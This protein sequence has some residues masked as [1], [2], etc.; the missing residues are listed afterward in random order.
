[1][2]DVI[3]DRTDRDT[4]IARARRRAA[5]NL[6]VE[7]IWPALLPSMA[8]VAA[9]TVLALLDLPQRLPLW[10]QVPLLVVVLVAAVQLAWVRLRHLPAPRS[11]LI[12]RRI[13]QA[14]GLRHRPMQALLDRPAGGGEAG[15]VWTAHLGRV[16][17]G[18]GRLDAGWPRLGLLRHDPYRLSLAL[19]P[20]LLVT[21]LV[22]GAD[23]PGRL[24]TGFLP[25]LVVPP[26]PMP[27]LQAWITPPDYAHAA[28]VFL[29]GGHDVVSVPAGSV[30][31]LSLTGVVGRPHLALHMLDASADPAGKVR[32]ER[33]AAGS[34]SLQRSL[35]AGTS[36]TL[37]ANGRALA[38]WTLQVTPAPQV[39]VAWNGT[40][41]PATQPWLTRLPW[42][43]SHPYGVSALAAEI[44]LADPVGS[45]GGRVS[46]GGAIAP[47]QVPVA[48]PPDARDAR[49]V[50]LPDL[51][52]DP[53]AGEAVIG[54]LLA[55][56]A[57]GHTAASTEARF[58]LPE[59]P[60]HNPLAR[61]VLEARKR[62][63]L[64]RETRAATAADLQA[65]G[66]APGAFATDP[67]LFLNLSSTAS[68]L[69][70]DDVRDQA[71]ISEATA[72][73]WNLALALEDG[74]RNDRAGARAL[75]DVRA[76][77]EALAQQLEHMRQLGDKGQ[78][79]AEQSEL[80]RRIQALQSAIARR[81][82]ALAEQARRDHTML[83]PMPDAKALTGGDLSR[84]MQQMRD[85][86]AQGN[87]REAMQQLQRMQSMLDRMRSATPQDLQSLRQ[88]AEAQAQVREQMQG[89]HDLEHRQ[90][91]LLDQSQARQGAQQREA[92]ARDGASQRG[93][94][95]EATAELLSRLGVSP[96]QEQ[97]F[98]PPNPDGRDDSATDPQAEAKRQAA[99]QAREKQRA[100]D[101]RT[102]HALS[103][104]LEEL[105]Q[106]F[107]SLTGRKP[108]GFDEAGRAMQQARQ[109][110]AAGQDQAAQQ[111]QQQA[112]A[113]L[114]KGGQ[115]MQQTLASS[116]GG[117]PML[118]PGMAGNNPSDDAGDAPGQ[119]AQGDGQDPHPGQRDP[120]GRPVGIGP[121]ADD[122]D[123]HVP[124][125]AERLRSR[126]IEQELRRRD[127]DRTRPPA[128]L[129]YLDRLLKSF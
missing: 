98:P 107:K 96:P 57:A 5:A 36:L 1:M 62:L 126:E 16:Q 112:L 12:D 9:Y 108:G 103:R 69:G 78:S 97:G 13:E 74:L 43:V 54:R 10:L 59:R 87:T 52:A 71:A 125:T 45:G 114:Q 93:Q 20:L 53:R 8:L 18:I 27:R 111:S 19:G 94:M 120:L 65:L 40:P 2:S 73:L 24:A 113:A 32:L 21:A 70:D 75:A 26:G 81:L 41:G 44:R 67:G 61:A 37:R 100:T 42:H 35:Q 129:D 30:L 80:D 101:S 15:L 83:P 63:A 56:D 46:G 14:S 92:Q 84:M 77:R 106:E 128:E 115:Q 33:L 47:L 58:R 39:L 91:D 38:D 85:A 119:E 116:K 118:L 89:L 31:Q 122:G 34:W 86:A 110:L 127:T 123:T 102:Q 95:D 60:F 79:S 99:G 68:L 90:A 50:A 17:A 11:D 7:Q 109:A 66:D 29:T 117:S 28:P 105:G 76:A 124:D 55:T 88:Q 51:S 25:G 121:H 6:R 48:L 22:A 4:A 104:A 72:R 64:G 3:P 49:G 23:L 82:Q